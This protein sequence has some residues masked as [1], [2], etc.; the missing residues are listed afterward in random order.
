MPRRNLGWIFALGFLWLLSSL[1]TSR[2]AQVVRYVLEEI[3]HRALEPADRKTLLAG[4][5]EGMMEKL[6]PHSVY[7]PPKEF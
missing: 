7:L 1:N 6:D 4:A 3:E 5:L 2:E